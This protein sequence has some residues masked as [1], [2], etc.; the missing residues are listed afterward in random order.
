[1]TIGATYSTDSKLTPPQRSVLIFMTNLCSQAAAAKDGR[2]WILEATNVN[3][4]LHVGNAE[5][6]AI[7]AKT[8]GAEAKAKVLAKA[9][10]RAKAKARV[11]EMER[12]TSQEGLVKER[13]KR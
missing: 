2:R 9:M 12:A 3:P 5:S 13:V 4:M 10:V 8:V 11:K 7:T 1:M 6:K